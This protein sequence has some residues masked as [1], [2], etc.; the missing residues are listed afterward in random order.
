MPT[1][2]KTWLLYWGPPLLWMGLIFY[3]SSIPGGEADT[4]TRQ[5]SGV[6]EPV[7]VQRIKDAVHIVEYGLLTLLLV[8]SFRKGMRGVSTG[9]VLKSFAIATMYGVSDEV[10]QVFVPLRSAGIEDV[11]W[12]VIG[13]GLAMVVVMGVGRAKRMSKKGTSARR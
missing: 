3:G 2:L 12:N 7:Q 9:Q 11:V 13:A 10:H 6:E 1:P 5:A 4:M 8:R